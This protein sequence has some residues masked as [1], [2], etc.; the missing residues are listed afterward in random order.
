MGRSQ[1]GSFVKIGE[2]AQ[3]AGV[4]VQTLHYYERCGFIKAPKRRASGYRDYPPKTVQEV[5]FIKRAQR[6]GF[7]LAGISDLLRLR[8]DEEADCRLVREAATAKMKA[9]HQKIEDLREIELALRQFIRSCRGPRPTRDCSILG[10]LDASR[11][12]AN[13]RAG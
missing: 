11:R 8:S 7:T 12:S 4:R 6:L 1:S 2:V 10:A 3:Q 9:I 13:R 5:Q